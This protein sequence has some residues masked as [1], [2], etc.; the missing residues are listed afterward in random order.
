MTRALCCRCER[1][2]AACICAF[3]TPVRNE[4]EVLILQHPSEAHEAKGTARLLQ[5]SLARCT[6][7]RGEHFDLPPADGRQT[8]LLYPRDEASGQSS[9]SQVMPSAI[10]LIVLDGTWRKSRKLLHL[11]PWLLAL[12]RYALQDAALSLYA[13]LRR[14]QAPG[15]LSTLEATALALM[16]REG[17]PECR[18]GGAGASDVLGAQNKAQAYEAL[19]KGLQGF[20][21]QSLRLAER[22]RGDLRRTETEK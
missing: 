16:Q 22:G 15:Q 5:L 21:E 7:L 8:W 18:R 4:V 14:A 2:A 19:L 10:R 11:N 20:V 6:L 9:S 12:P 17:D 3:V 1:P 13:P